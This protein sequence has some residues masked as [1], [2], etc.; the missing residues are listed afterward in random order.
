[1]A[2]TLH[3]A[4]PYILYKVVSA[5]PPSLTTTLGAT[6]TFTIACAGVLPTHN[7]EVWCKNLSEGL[8]LGKAFC[9]TAGTVVVPIVN[10]SGGTVDDAAKDFHILVR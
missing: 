8:L 1:M 3:T 10:T 4:Q 9:S 5:N 6:L 7:V 2:N